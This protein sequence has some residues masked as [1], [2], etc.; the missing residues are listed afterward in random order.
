MQN[1]RWAAAKPNDFRLTKMGSFFRAWMTCFRIANFSCE[2]P[3]LCRVNRLAQSGIHTH[4]QGTH[5]KPKVF[6]V[7]LCPC[8][9]ESEHMPRR[10]RILSHPLLP[11]PS[12]GSV[13]R[14]RR[15][16]NDPHNRICRLLVCLDQALVQPEVLSRPC[17]CCLQSKG[18]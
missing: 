13:R 15:V 5:G 8:C 17:H 14:K 4:T 12:P 18:C 10:R 1:V 11:L 9:G 16:E 7:A 3:L 6:K 2:A